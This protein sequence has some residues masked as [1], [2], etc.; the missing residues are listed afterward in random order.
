MLTSASQRPS[1]SATQ[2]AAV[3]T[4]SA[5]ATSSW[6]CRTPSADA[7]RALLRVSRAEHHRVATGGELPT[8]LVTNTAIGP[9]DDG[10]RSVVRHRKQLL[11]SGPP[12]GVGLTHFGRTEPGRRPPAAQRH[13][14]AAPT[15]R[16]QTRRSPAPRPPCIA[17]GGCRDGG[18][19]TE[20][21]CLID[22]TALYRTS[23]VDDL[24]GNGAGRRRLLADVDSEPAS[25][26]GA[27]RGCPGARFVADHWLNW[28]AA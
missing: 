5:S 18:A 4:L 3:C 12:S 23:A 21:P 15:R 24:P 20:R 11:A 17:I 9:G 7:A 27:A 25:R 16:Q 14:P 22:L 1:R 19:G 28:N 26:R 10:D 6:Q 8:H 2:A 13:R